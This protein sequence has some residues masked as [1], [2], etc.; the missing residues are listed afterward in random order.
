MLTHHHRTV[1]HSGISA[2][3]GWAGSMQKFYSKWLG[4]F[5]GNM[6]SEKADKIL[7]NGLITKEASQLFM[8]GWNDAQKLW[9]EKLAKRV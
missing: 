3:D 4:E 2:F 7:H 9:K 1:Y 6:P 8:E 5:D